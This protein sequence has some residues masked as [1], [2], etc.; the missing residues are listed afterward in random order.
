MRQRLNSEELDLRK[1]LRIDKN[2]LDNELIRQPELFYH[3]STSYALCVSQRDQA[4]LDLERAEAEADSKI[5]RAAVKDDKVKKIT[6]AEIVARRAMAPE[7][8]EA[9]DSYLSARAAVERAAALRDAYQ[10]RGYAV[11]DL[12]NLYVSGYYGAVTGRFERGEAL[13]KRA[14]EN[15]AVLAQRRRADD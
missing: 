15:R 4:K 1:C 9:Q 14:A 5:R 2:D 12:V 11:K 3:A 10:Q 7:V 13:D 8:R 6:E